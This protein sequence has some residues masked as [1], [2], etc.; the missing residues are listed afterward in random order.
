MTLV[1]LA[2][3]LAINAVVTGFLFPS[4]K[5]VMQDRR[6]NT[7]SAE[8]TRAVILAR[9]EAMKRGETIFSTAIDGSDAANEWGKGFRVW[10]DESGDSVYQS[11]QDTEIYTFT[12]ISDTMTIDANTIQVQVTSRGL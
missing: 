5:T 12:G 4:F 7:A 9:S 2:V 6:F 11:D 8:V 10:Q 1:E 3:V